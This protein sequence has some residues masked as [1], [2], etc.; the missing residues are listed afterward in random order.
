MIRVSCVLLVLALVLPGAVVSAPVEQVRVDVLTERTS[1][2][3]STALT[4]GPVSPER[5]HLEQNPSSIS[6]DTQTWRLLVTWVG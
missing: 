6:N 3:N 5:L 1:D 4:L 2:L